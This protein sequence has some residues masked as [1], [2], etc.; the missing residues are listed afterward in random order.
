MTVLV[1][2]VR[3]AA[4]ADLDFGPG[5]PMAP[6]RLTLAMALIEALGLLD[7]PGVEVV[8]APLPV[9]DDH[10]LAV[11]DAA[12]VDAVRAAS[13]D[14]RGADGAFG[15]G[16]PDV[17]AFSGMHDAARRVVGASVDAAL[18]VWRGSAVH[19]VNAAGGLHHAMPGRAA[20]FCVYND[21]SAA[22]AA[23]LADGCG[24]IAYLDVDAHHG[25]GVEAA[26]LDDPR[27][28]TVSVHESPE[29]LF[30]GTGPTGDAAG[31]SAPGTALSLALPAGSGDGPWLAAVATALEHVERFA[32][33]VIVSQ[34]GADTH[35]EDHLTHL[36]VSVD[37]QRAAAIAVHEAAHRVAQGRWLALGGGGYSLVHVVPRAWAHLV[38]VAAH[39]PVPLEEPVPQAWREHVLTVT[40]LVAPFMMGDAP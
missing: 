32:P 36:C 11:H 13:A 22:I 26:F 1:R 3:D 39:A 33:D 2:V 9:D 6:V 37:A 31:P 16:T 4:L 8:P 12:F 24:R 19:A 40:D 10:L 27:V 28:L 23:L 38:A 17:P 5:H 21:A 35:R 34:H 7:A 25:D 20:G 30:P 18:A 29:T 14:P 15:L